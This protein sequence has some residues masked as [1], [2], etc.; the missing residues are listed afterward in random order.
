M[1]A[2]A[3]PFTALVDVAAALAASAVA[4]PWLALSA[5]LSAAGLALSGVAAAIQFDEWRL[6]RRSPSV[7]RPRRWS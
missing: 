5:L 2:I 7:R 4:E 3:G 6:E 1:T